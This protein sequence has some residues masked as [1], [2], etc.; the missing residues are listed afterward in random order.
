[1]IKHRDI[2]ELVGWAIFALG[3]GGVW[4][5]WHA[6]MMVGAMVGIASIVG[7]LRA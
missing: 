7:R 3:C 2:V 6:A 5:P 4:G 1:M